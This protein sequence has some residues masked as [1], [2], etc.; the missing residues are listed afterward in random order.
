MIFIQ[1]PEKHDA[2]GVLLLAKSGSAVSCLADN[3]YGVSPEHINLLKRKRITFKKLP[4][5][6]VPLPKSPLA[7]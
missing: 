5:K 3:V 7:A 2:K 6:S 4:A 1:L